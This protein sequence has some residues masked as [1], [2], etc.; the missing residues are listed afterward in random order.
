MS[1]L[2]AQ[3]RRSESDMCRILVEDALTARGQKEKKNGS[4]R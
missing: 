3:E 1:G 2:A 4:K